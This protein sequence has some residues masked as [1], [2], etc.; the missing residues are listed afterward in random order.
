M[1][2]RRELLEEAPFVFNA[3][4]LASASNGRTLLVSNATRPSVSANNT[5]LLTKHSVQSAAS[6]ARDHQRYGRLSATRTSASALTGRLSASQSPA[7][8]TMKAAP[9]TLPNVLVSLACPT[10]PVPP[11]SNNTPHGTSSAREPYLQDALVAHKTVSTD[12]KIASL[13]FVVMF[14]LWLVASSPIS[15]MLVSLTTL[16]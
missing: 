9:A 5:R 2:A 11:V 14:T 10:A 13:P 3:R 16:A 12:A 6:T 7:L 8:N 1:S 4:L 15:T